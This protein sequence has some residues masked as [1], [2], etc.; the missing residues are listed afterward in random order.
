MY[1]LLADEQFK[2][3]GMRKAAWSTLEG[4][5]PQCFEMRG[6][7]CPGNTISKRMLRQE[8]LEI[9]TMTGWRRRLSLLVRPRFLTVCQRLIITL[10]SPFIYHFIKKE[11][12]CNGKKTSNRSC[13]GFTFRYCDVIWGAGE[14]NPPQSSTITE[15]SESRD[16]RLFQDP[17]KKT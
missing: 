9:I 14:E 10:M 1:W 8:A 12:I 5:S 3:S 11:Q 15:H 7:T 6:Y 17:V 13:Y 2:L 4:G 16:Q